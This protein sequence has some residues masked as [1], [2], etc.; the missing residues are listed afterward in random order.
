MDNV[1]RPCRLVRNRPS[2]SNLKGSLFFFLSCSERESIQSAP[3]IRWAFLVQYCTAL[4]ATQAKYVCTVDQ[5]DVIIV[6]EW[7]GI[8]ATRSNSFSKIP[9]RVHLRVHWAV[10]VCFSFLN[11]SSKG[12][13][14]LYDVKTVD[15]RS[16][17]PFILWLFNRS[18]LSIPFFQR[19]I[20]EQ[21]AM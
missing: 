12:G 6:I 5:P 2:G 4:V 17:S 15:I 8:E 13:G 10:R 16:E 7:K 1:F 20:E 19:S 21:S 3:V 11:Q 14:N 9:L 18:S